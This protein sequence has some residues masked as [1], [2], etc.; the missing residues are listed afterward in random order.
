M[1]SKRAWVQIAHDNSYNLLFNFKYKNYSISKMN[2]FYKKHA[3]RNR[4]SIHVFCNAWVINKVHT[5]QNQIKI[6]IILPT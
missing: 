5:T 4:K 6:F 2:L 3:L 1:N